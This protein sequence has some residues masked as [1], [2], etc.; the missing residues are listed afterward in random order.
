LKLEIPKAPANA[1]SAQHRPD[2]FVK[3]RNRR[4]QAFLQRN[5][6]FP[7]ERIARTGNVRLA[8]TGVI[9]R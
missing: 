2:F 3:I 9:L 5:R 6:R 7:V 4:L 8:L 1:G